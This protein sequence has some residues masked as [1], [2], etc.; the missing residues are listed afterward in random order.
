VTGV[1]AAGADKCCKDHLATVAPASWS[2]VCGFFI[3]CI[4]ALASTKR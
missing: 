1:T 3:L 4:Q 2:L